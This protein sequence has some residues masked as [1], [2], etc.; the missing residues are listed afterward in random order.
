[1]AAVEVAAVEAAAEEAA[2]AAAEEAAAAGDV[3][4]QSEGD[5]WTM[6]L[7]ASQAR[8][9]GS[10]N[11]AVGRR[12]IGSRVDEGRVAYAPGPA[13]HFAL[14]HRENVIL[15]TYRRQRSLRPI[16]IARK[17]SLHSERVGSK[18]CLVGRRLGGRIDD[19]ARCESSANDR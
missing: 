7:S 19:V 5:Y 14:A 15:Y 4:Y 11:W 3:G 10:N 12:V 1:V 6:S 9:N 18:D 2:A 17:S 13:R 16:P 8:V